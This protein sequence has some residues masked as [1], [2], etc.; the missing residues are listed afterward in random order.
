MLFGG[1]SDLRRIKKNSQPWHSS[2]LEANRVSGSL[3]H[4]N[5]VLNS[6]LLY[7]CV[8]SAKVM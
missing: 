7:F 6:E 5:D 1:L 2:C 8:F 3:H 4:T